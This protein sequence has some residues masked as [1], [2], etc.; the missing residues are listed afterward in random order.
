MGKKSKVFYRLEINSNSS[1]LFYYFFILPEKSK[2]NTIALTHLDIVNMTLR[3]G[4]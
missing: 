2:T 3:E 4:M 1:P